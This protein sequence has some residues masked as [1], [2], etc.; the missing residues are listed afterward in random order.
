[1]QV[2][3]GADHK[4]EHI[5]TV[6][7]QAEGQTIADKAAQFFELVNQDHWYSASK[8]RIILTLSMNLDLRSR[9]EDA[10]LR[11]PHRRDRA[12][13]LSFETALRAS[14]G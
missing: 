12:R 1:L 6:I 4:L 13:G 8:I 3:T 7:R 9:P 2:V 14:S 11:E 5:D 10:V